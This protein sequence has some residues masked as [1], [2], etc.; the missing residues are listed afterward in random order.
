TGI[1]LDPYYTASGNLLTWT[2]VTWDERF[3]SKSYSDVIVYQSDL[4]K[5]TFLTRKQRY[6]S[7]AFS[8]DGTRIVVVES[9]YSNNC[10]LIIL[11]SKTG[12]KLTTLP[13]PEF[14][15]YTYPKWD[16]DGKSIITSA[17]TLSGK[18]IIIQQLPGD[19]SINK[20][21][22]EYNHNIGE[23]LVTPAT[24]LFSASFSGTNNLFSLNR[25]NG[26]IIQLTGS[27]FGA[28]Y[29]AMSP[30]GMKLV[31]SDFNITGYGL[32][33]ASTDSLLMKAVEPVPLNKMEM[34]DFSY[35]Q[36]EG[37]NIFDKIPD[38]KLEISPYN[39]WKHP[40]R[41]HSWIIS[42]GYY[43]AGI[44]LISDNI[45]NNLHVEG[46]FNYY[47][48][49]SSPGFSAK[50]QYGG[51]YPVLSAGISR[52]YRQADELSVMLGTDT[53]RTISLDNQFS[54]EL[55]VPLNFTKGEY[56]R[57]ADISL[58]YNYIF[59]KNLREGNSINDNSL[60]VSALAGKA[61]FLSVMKKAYQNISTPIGVGLELSA[62]QSIGFTNA[63][64]YQAI[65]DFAVRGL[66]PN[67]NLILSAGWKYEPD[68]DR[69]HFMDLFLYPR[70]YLIPRYNS[71]FTLQ[72]TYHFPLFYPDFGFWGIV[73]C[74]RVR[75]SVFA[76][77][78]YALIPDSFNNFSNKAFA[79]VGSEL[80][81]DTKWFNLASIPLGIRFSLLL[82]PDNEDPQRKTRLEIIIPV[83]R[84]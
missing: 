26:F 24:I 14:L 58:G 51:I 9:D 56:Y 72:S 77:Y 36:K 83:L 37:G 46:G 21:S 10:R 34:F 20:L 75:T 30:D 44:N 76:D 49:E 41:L 78:G 66:F 59:V 68:K 82:T 48:N 7:P 43:S 18:S 33:M 67:H 31:Y 22:S 16:I 17:R 2:E 71:M 55:Q 5:K 6:F 1:S 64:Q 47:Y 79:S 73:Y 45:F 63:S 80:I 13:N 53:A 8:P 61:R 40:V 60:Y 69:Y 81:F 35:F 27:K 70:G 32:V 57:H 74:S 42:P 12:T 4:S 25:G 50:V 65:G 11:D 52:Y 3:S 62:S 84:L 38:Q 19:G 28:Y 54:L 23:V 15:Y 29:P 39:L